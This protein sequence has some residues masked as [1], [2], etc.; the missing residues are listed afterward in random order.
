MIRF[1]PPDANATIRLDEIDWG[2]VAVNG[3]PPL[4]HPPTAEATSATW[5]G[6]EDIVFGVL[7]DGVA[8]AY[9]KKIVAWHEMVRDQVGQTPIALVYCTLCGSV[10]PYDT[11]VD[12]QSY[13]FGTSGLLYRSNKLMFDEETLTLWSSIYGRPVVGSLVAEGRQLKRLPVVTTSWKEW[14][15]MHPETSVLTP[16]TGHRR[17]YSEGA[18][19]A[20]YNATDRLWFEVPQTDDRLPNKT[21]VVTLV[22][23]DQPLALTRDF[24]KASPLYTH[25]LGGERV[26]FVTDGSGGSRA[27]RIG[28]QQF[29]E[30]VDARTLVDST[31]NR[32]TLSEDSLSYE[33]QT[34]DRL[35]T[36]P[37][38][39]FGWF[40]Q[41]PETELVAQ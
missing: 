30:R 25:T 23:A 1:F 19:Y 29:V 35:A 6:A 39:W 22:H 33:A 21:E 27:Y 37:A 5:M 4:D 31:G 11:R 10:I 3:V 28:D 41:H 12:G 34:L 13:T 20:D 15:A 16:E 18:A 40:A 17:D 24:L 2:G 9:P 38:F 14:T 7:I 36:S 26:L 8:K 32:W